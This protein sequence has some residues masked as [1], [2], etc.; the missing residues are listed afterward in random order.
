M[1]PSGES[2]DL[3]LA[4]LANQPDPSAPA[5]SLINSVVNSRLT[6]IE[7]LHAV[8][9]DDDALA[10]SGEV[11]EL[12]VQ[13]ELWQ[14]AESC[15]QI[16]GDILAGRGDRHGACLNWREAIA[17]AI[18]QNRPADYL[19][20]LVEPTEGNCGRPLDSPCEAC[21]RMLGADVVPAA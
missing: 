21:A 19:A 11:L 20:Q 10:L 9:R 4:V 3:Y 13:Y 7:V 5:H 6:Y 2:Q 15:R 18:R 17:L 1:K 16:T 14:H 8:G 12:S